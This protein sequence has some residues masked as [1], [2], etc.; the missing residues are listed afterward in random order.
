MDRR[1]ILGGVLFAGG[2]G[3]VRVL[4]YRP[5]LKKNSRILVI[6]DSLAVGM[7]PHFELL[8][9]ETELPF[10]ARAIGGTRVD[11]WV[12]SKKLL[13]LLDTFQPTHVLISL[14]TNDAYTP[15]KPEN[16]NADTQELVAIIKEANANP[17]WIGAPDL[18]T[19]VNCPPCPSGE[20]DLRTENLAAIK[21]AAPYYFDSTTLNIPKSPDGIHP[22]ARGYAGW[23][24]AIWNWLT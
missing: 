6:G 17:I 14:G 9:K 7:T 18:P 21:E 23:A 20:F 3:L 13:S 22:T 19:P 8:A 10:S 24:G 1:W 16:V 4:T 2:I 11:Q 15:L 5:K 12:D